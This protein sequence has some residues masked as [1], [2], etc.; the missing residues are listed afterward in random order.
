MMKT[1]RND[2]IRQQQNK[3][4]TKWQ[5]NDENSKKIWQENNECQKNAKID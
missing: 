1:K 3:K 4:I 2:E 5:K